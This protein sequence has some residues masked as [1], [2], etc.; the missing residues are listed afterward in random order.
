MKWRAHR[1]SGSPFPTVRQEPW[2]AVRRPAGAKPPGFPDARDAADHR[3]RQPPPTDRRGLALPAPQRADLPRRCRVPRFWIWRS[4]SKDLDVMVVEHRA[5]VVIFNV[6]DNLAHDFV[7]VPAVIA[8]A[9]DADRKCLPAVLVGHLGNG[10][11]E[12]AA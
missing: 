2:P 8:G 7:R 10:N 3:G 6:V 12:T 4:C 11:V 9:G 5:P 1:S